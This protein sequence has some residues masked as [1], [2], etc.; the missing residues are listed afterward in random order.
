MRIMFRKQKNNRETFCRFPCGTWQLFRQY[1]NYD[2]IFYSDFVLYR[3]LVARFAFSLATSYSQVNQL[4][5]YVISSSFVIS[6]LKRKRL[7]FVGPYFLQ[8]DCH[9]CPQRNEYRRARPT[10]CD[11]KQ[12]VGKIYHGVQLQNTPTQFFLV[13]KLQWHHKHST[14]HLCIHIFVHFC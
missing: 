5:A 4:N 6:S 3:Q 2:Y 12:C 9:P 10:R 13:V 14:D 11:E 7:G 8:I 1:F